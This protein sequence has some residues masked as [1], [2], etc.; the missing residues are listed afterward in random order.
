[1]I[2]VKNNFTLACHWAFPKDQGG[3]GMHNLYLVNM[4]HKHF[5]I[6]IISSS[7]EINEKYYSQKRIAFKGFK[8]SY[9]KIFL[10]T[11]SKGILN[12]GFRSINDLLVSYRIS[13]ILKEDNPDVVEFIDIHSNSYRYLKN[14]KNRRKT[15]IIIRSHTPW[16]LLRNY[17]K[18][19][20]IKKTDTLWAMSRENYCFKN[21]DHITVPSNDLKERLIDIFKTSQDKIKV[22]PN[23]LDT[24][25]FF[26]FERNN[27]DSFTILHTGRLERAKGIETLVKTFIK[28]ASVHKNIKL[29]VIGEARGN[30]KVECINWLIKAGLINRVTFTGFVEYEKLPNYYANSDIVVVTS[31]IYESFSYTVAQGMACGKPVIASNIGGI[32]ETLDN[33][34]AGLLFEPGNV[35]DLFSSIEQLYFD[36][37]LRN[38]YGERARK[39]A[40]NN[41]SFKALEN[42]YSRFYN[43]LL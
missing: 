8:L 2:N 32:P 6:S 5:N 39:Y 37:S 16:S 40:L 35:D 30:S 38:Y 17:Y 34:N 28:F 9:P 18:P 19:H 15:K 42:R 43:S 25:H 12:R 4:L 10:E 21:C 36:S 20:E 13:N 24:K 33:G 1:M 41:F 27:D 29:V 23:I 31:E 26:P 14:D 11:M 22:L 3:I 7:N